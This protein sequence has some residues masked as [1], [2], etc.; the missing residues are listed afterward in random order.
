MTSSTV[1]IQQRLHELL[2][3][4]APR[5]DLV[6]MKAK[7]E[8]LLDDIGFRN[9][10]TQERAMK[11]LE[12]ILEHYQQSLTDTYEQTKRDLFKLVAQL[13]YPSRQ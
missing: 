2:G 9:R 10:E 3:N 13:E 5:V 7:L 1:R 12:E 11:Q 8:A 4:A 6:D